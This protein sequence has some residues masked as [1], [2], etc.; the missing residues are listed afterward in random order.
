MY[1]IIWLVLMGIVDWSIRNMAGQDHYVQILGA[2][3]SVFEIILGIVGATV[4]CHLFLHRSS[5]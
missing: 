2:D 1:A 4:A 5:T 3:P